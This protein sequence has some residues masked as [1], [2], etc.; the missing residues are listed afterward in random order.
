MGPVHPLAGRGFS[1]TSP[2]NAYAKTGDGAGEKTGASAINMA[3]FAGFLHVGVS[4]GG[5]A[6]AGER[7]GT[8]GLVGR[9]E[10][11]NRKI[12]G[13]PR[14]APGWCRCGIGG[15]GGGRGAAG[16]PRCQS[17]DGDCI[18]TILIRYQTNIWRQPEKHIAG[19]NPPGRPNRPCCKGNWYHF[20]RSSRRPKSRDMACLAR[21]RVS[22]AV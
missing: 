20:Q 17:C 9:G 1:L 6:V 16:H 15:G 2:G 4:A 7:S 8:A 3:F 13:S 14:A 5:R 18:I 22:S 21:A 19:R 10:K 11:K 12:S